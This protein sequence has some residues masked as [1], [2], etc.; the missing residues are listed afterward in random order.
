MLCTFLLLLAFRFDAIQA[1]DQRCHH[2]ATSSFMVL[3]EN[4]SQKG[5]EN[6]NECN[7]S[8]KPNDNC[9]CFSSIVAII[10]ARMIVIR[11]VAVKHVLRIPHIA[12][13]EINLA[14]HSIPTR[15]LEPLHGRIHA[16]VAVG[17]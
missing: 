4:L 8:K 11:R 6:N 10:T 13:A 14:R 7:S 12:F 9:H 1:A 3:L 17:H 15:V 16:V 5:E 2:Y